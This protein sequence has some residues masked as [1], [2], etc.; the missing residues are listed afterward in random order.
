M[1]HPQPYTAAL[2]ALQ[3]K[4]VTPRQ[5]VQSELGA[6]LSTPPLK[7]GDAN[8]FDSFALSIESLVGMLRA[9]EG[10]NGYELLCGSHVDCLL[11]KLPPAYRDSFVEYCLSRGIL[12]T[13][14]DKTYTLPDFADWLQIKSQ[15]KRISSR[16]TAMFQSETP[17]APGRARGAPHPREQ[18][19]PVL[20]TREST[21]KTP[22][23]TAPKFSFKPKPYCP[24][25]DNREHYLNSCEAFK[26]LTTSQIV[27]WIKDSKHCWRCGRFHAV[28]SCNLKRPCTI[29]KEL[30][31]T[32]LH[33]SI[34]DT[35][36]AI[37]TVSLPSTRVYLDR[38][39]RTPRVM[40]KVVKVLL[41]NGHHTMEAHAVLD[42]GSERT[43]VLSPVVQQL[44]L[45]YTPELLH[46]QTV[47]QS[48]TELVG[49]SISFEVSSVTKPMQRFT[50]PNAFTATGLSLAEHNYPVAVLQRAYRHLRA[51]PL[52]PG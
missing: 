42:D 30:H 50:I 20:L 24:H 38:P 6:I 23:P 49:S 47:Q 5:L 11:S 41:H 52:P 25:C 32:V 3:D 40:L 18:P 33:N 7:F 4:Y 37:L 46:L 26:K 21:T 22:E 28:E 29:C 36:S 15:A 34:K 35:T 13:G 14:T 17:K 8:A 39:N 48:H 1:Y 19:R 43:L 9:L 2:Q 27:A 10:Q 51:L 12:Q 45:T 16:A 44:K 31:L